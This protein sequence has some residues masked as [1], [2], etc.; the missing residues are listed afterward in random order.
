MVIDQRARGGQREREKERERN[1]KN[2]GT[3]GSN[4]FSDDSRRQERIFTIQFA[5]DN[6]DQR[7][8]V[9]WQLRCALN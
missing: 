8:T 6:I 9:S 7:V 2:R 5:Y 3:D 1:R 4:Y